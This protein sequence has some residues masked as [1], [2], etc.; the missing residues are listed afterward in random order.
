MNRFFELARKM[1]YKS[2]Y[3][4]Q[5]G[6]VIVQG[7]KVLGLGFNEL[8]THT[9]SPDPFQMKHCEFSAI[10]NA[11]REDFTGCEI[12]IYRQLKDENPAPAKPCINC[13]K[14]L[15]NLNFYKIHYSVYGGFKS[16]II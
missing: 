12:Y 4:H 1:S 2:Q 10:L 7:K 6:S 9:K 3:R 11:R 14:M 15:K 8:K 13:F 16:E 5:M